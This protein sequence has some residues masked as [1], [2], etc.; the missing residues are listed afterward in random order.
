MSLI[1]S[2]YTPAEERL[3]AISHG[4][5]V[6]LSIVGL[7]WMLYISIESADPWRV[8]ASLVYGCSLILLFLSSTIYHALHASPHSHIYKLLDHCA[9]YLLIAG[10]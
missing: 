10:T 8:T 4:V 2:S 5:G 9:I 3:H 7:S 1:P 6:L